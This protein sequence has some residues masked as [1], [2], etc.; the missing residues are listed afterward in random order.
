MLNGRQCDLHEM[1]L[2][3]D[4]LSNDEYYIWHWLFQDSDGDEIT[5]LYDNCIFVKNSTQLDSDGD[6]LG[7]DCDKCPDNFDPDQKDSDDDGVPNACD[8]CKNY[9]DD[10]DIDQ[11]GIPDECDNCPFKSNPDQKDSD[12]DGIGNACDNCPEVK[13]PREMHEMNSEFVLAQKK[14]AKDKGFCKNLYSS[15][16][17]SRNICMMQ[18]DS[19]LAI[20]STIPP[21]SSILAMYPL[22]FS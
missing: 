6:G 21:S 3:N 17:E 19:D 15:T 1:M 18:P 5:D 12:G 2:D 16:W 9:P 13:N 11:D 22:A 7:D 14:G 8:R 20:A 10:N 4:G